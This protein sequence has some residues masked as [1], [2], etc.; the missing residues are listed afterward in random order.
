M[1]LNSVFA[2]GLLRLIKERNPPV[3]ILLVVPGKIRIASVWQVL[4]FFLI[5]IL[6]LLKDLSKKHF[7]VSLVVI[8][9]ISY[10]IS[11]L[12]IYEAVRDYEHAF[13][14]KTP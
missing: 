3:S 4:Y 14:P 12:L 13:E 7:L 5:S 9:L 6:W 8:D 10:L 2:K 11:G 1:Q